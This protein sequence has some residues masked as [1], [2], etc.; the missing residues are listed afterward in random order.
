LKDAGHDVEVIGVCSECHKLSARF[1]TTNKCQK[2][3]FPSC[4]VA[5]RPE[6]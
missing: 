5:W 2:V 4:P 6:F 1:I 3:N